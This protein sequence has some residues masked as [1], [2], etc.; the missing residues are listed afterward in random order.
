MEAKELRIGNLVYNARNKV[1]IVDWLTIKWDEDFKPIP[2][3]EEWL[4]KAKF[5]NWGTT[6][7]NEFE[8]YTDYVLFNVIEGTSSFKVSFIESNYGNKYYSEFTIK[9]DH[10]AIYVKELLYIHQLQN[11]FYDLTGM[12]LEFINK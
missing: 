5:E 12:E 10:D 2:L 9:I 7:L 11:I 6:Q 4:L 3:T 8:K 1:I